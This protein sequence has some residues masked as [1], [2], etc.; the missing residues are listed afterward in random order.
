MNKRIPILY[1]TFNLDLITHS[2]TGI[3]AMF[4]II[5]PVHKSMRDLKPCS[6]IHTRFENLVLVY[7]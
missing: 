2:N 5:V 7:V 6:S 3:F 1:T 4:C